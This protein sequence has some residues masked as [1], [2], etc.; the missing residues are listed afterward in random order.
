M[1]AISIDQPWASLVVS[2]IMDVTP[3]L[4]VLRDYRGPVLVVSI[5]SSDAVSELER[6]PYEWLQVVMNRIYLGDLPE[7]NEMPMNKALGVVDIIDCVKDA[8]SMWDNWQNNGDVL[9]LANARIFD[10]PISSWKDIDV[11]NLPP[12]HVFK[13]HIPVYENG[14]LILHVGPT[15]YDRYC[16][17]EF[18]SVSLFIDEDV[19]ACGIF[20]DLSSFDTAPLDRVELV[21][22]NQ[23]AVF[24][25]NNVGAGVPLDEKGDE[26]Y[27]PS[28]YEEKRPW[29]SLKIVLGPRKM[30]VV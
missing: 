8:Y 12:F 13:K 15:A 19:E 11:D 7:L 17:G 24:G 9:R 18:F 22:G 2:G 21:C 16:S 5:K 1:K 30:W 14:K 23:R 27:F 20:P 3:S 29:E 28:I 6:A 10:T 26:I 4:P 25:V